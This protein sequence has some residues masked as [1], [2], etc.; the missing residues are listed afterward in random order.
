MGVARMAQF[1]PEMKNV[2]EKLSDN[3]MHS[4]EA[5]G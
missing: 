4:S 2:V 1:G 3:R 5:L